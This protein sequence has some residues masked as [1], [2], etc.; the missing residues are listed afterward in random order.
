MDTFVQELERE[1][2]YI[3]A[4]TQLQRNEHWDELQGGVEWLIQVEEG[5]PESGPIDGVYWICFSVTP[6]QA[7]SHIFPMNKKLWHNSLC[8]ACRLRVNSN[9]TGPSVPL[10]V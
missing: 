2:R 9:S 10:I 7:C 4:V 1:A 3:S 6:G 5:R 8:P